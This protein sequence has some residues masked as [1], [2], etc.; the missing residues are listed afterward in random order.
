M[1]AS[2]SSLGMTPHFTIRVW[3]SP[4]RSHDQLSDLAGRRRRR[5]PVALIEVDTT[6][7]AGEL[8]ISPH[9]GLDFIP[10]K[11]L[12][13]GSRLTPMAEVR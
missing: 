4:G 10:Q 13:S 1:S 12:P 8:S 5:R 11:M 6:E 2:N 7:E 3:E 9:R